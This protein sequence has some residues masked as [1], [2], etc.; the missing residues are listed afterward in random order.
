MRRKMLPCTEEEENSHTEM[1]EFVEI[2]PTDAHSD[3][4]LYVSVV[5]ITPERANCVGA[6]GV[7]STR[8]GE[9]FIYVLVAVT[10]RE[11][12]WAC[13][14]ARG[15]IADGR[16]TLAVTQARTLR[17]PSVLTRCMI[18]HIMSNKSMCLIVMQKTGFLN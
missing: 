5:T 2:A 12:W 8:R 3:A 16:W 6:V 1:R 10:S 11:P 18:E 4:L 14:A 9:T 7:R 13:S 17:A 15:W